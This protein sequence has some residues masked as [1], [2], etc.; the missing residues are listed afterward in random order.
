MKKGFLLL[1]LL[2]GFMACTAQSEKKP[3]NFKVNKTE[4][5]WKKELTPEQ[6]R[7][8]RQKGTERP[9]TNKYNH[10]NEQG[11]YAC[12]ACSYE[13]FSSEHKYDSGSGWPAFD[14]PINKSA[15]F[16]KYGSILWY[17]FALKFY[18]PTAEVIWVM[19]LMT[20]QRKRQECDIV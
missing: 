13:L 3:D 2:G 15:V 6:Y 5:E 4:E 19:Y 9:G 12:A 14:R 8:L 10:H 16:E 1:I 17:G 7:V 11:V 20:D 18:V